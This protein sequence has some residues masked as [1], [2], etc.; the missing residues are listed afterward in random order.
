MPTEST[1]VT[2]ADFLLLVC[3]NGTETAL[4]GKLISGCRKDFIPVNCC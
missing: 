3:V 2:G 1:S 4:A